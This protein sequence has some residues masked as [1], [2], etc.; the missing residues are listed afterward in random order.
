MR[1]PINVLDSLRSKAQDSTYHY[2]RLYRNLYNSEFFLVAYQNIYA[3]SGNM[4][5]GTDGKTVD[6]MG[7][8]R[9]NQLI[10][11]LKDHSYHPK[12]ARRTYIKKKNGKLRPLGVPSFDDK[13]IQEIVRMLLEAIYEPT[14][15][16]CSHGFRPN[17]SCHTALLQLQKKFNG[18]KWF[19]EGDIKS[20][21]DNIDHAVLISILRRRI[22]DEHLI[23]LIWKFLK[24]GYLEDWKY[25]KTYSGTPQGSIISPILSNIYLNELDRFMEEYAK[26]YNTNTKRGYYSPYGKLKAKAKWMRHKYSPSQWQALEQSKK[27]EHLKSIKEIYKQMRQ[28]PSHNPMDSNVKSVQYVRYADDWICGVIGSKSDAEKIKADIKQFLE[29][30]L[31]LEL[32]EEK[33]LITHSQNKARFLGFDVC[34]SCS[35]QGQKSG[36]GSM[37]RYHSGRIELYVPKEKW[38][39]KLI[40]YHA[41]KIKYQNGQE[42]FEPTQRPYL[43]NNDDLEILTQYNAEIRGIYNYYRIASNVSILG[44]F[45]YVMKFSLYKTFA[46]KYKS[47]VRKILKKYGRNPFRVQYE[48][49][50][51]TKIMELYNNGFKKD[52]NGIILPNIDITPFVHR[53]SNPTSLVE[54]LKANKC[55]WCGAEDTPIEIHHVKKLKDLKGK[56]LWEIV[57]I[58]RKR[59]TMALCHQCH[60]KLHAGLLD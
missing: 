2:K 4:T 23:A 27:E 56:A 14:F 25:H 37:C 47:T 44:K 57:M 55:E 16:E 20:F 36:N 58:G 43:S 52:K 48:T 45:F 31:K 18:A 42:I 12:P 59:K 54:R 26:T 35:N 15:S 3:N 39:G 17:R 22:H 30:A 53:N 10:E 50:K 29:S 11:H 49:S 41:L 7:M 9:I 32:S 51:G 60:V 21:F 1:N 46:N 34:T 24:A 33:T 13:L 6:G 28:L 8:G 19:I 5:A 38:Q 40:S